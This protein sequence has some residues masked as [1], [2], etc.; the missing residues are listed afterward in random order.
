MYA[1]VCNFPGLDEKLLA[2]V[3]KSFDAEPFCYAVEEN[4]SGVE[5]KCYAARQILSVGGRIF[6]AREPSF[7][8]NRVSS[9]NDLQNLQVLEEKPAHS[10]TILQLKPD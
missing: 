9:F 6:Y 7:S 8:D 5:Q 10:A 3:A 2:R 4:L 1:R